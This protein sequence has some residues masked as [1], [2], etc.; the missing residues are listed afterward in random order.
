MAPSLS[1]FLCSL[2]A[3][4]ALARAATVTYN[5]NA[6]WT[7]AD[8]DGQGRRAVMGFNNQ[9]PIP[10]IVATVGDRV[11]VN[12]FNGL[13]NESTSLHF[14]GLYQNG[15]TYMDGPVGVTQCAVPPGGRITYNFT[16]SVHAG[17]GAV[18]P[19]S[20]A[21]LSLPP[22]YRSTNLVPIG[23]IHTYAGST[24]MACAVP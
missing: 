10:A 17:G 12:L 8:P 7:Y 18:A 6:T 15:T 22:L 24:P 19:R 16:V 13:G 11:V 21:E 5:L 3:L 20:R 2:T 4:S 23:T 1:H 9:W 14:H